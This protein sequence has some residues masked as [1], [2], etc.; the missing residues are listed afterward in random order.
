MP[1][2]K[3]SVPWRWQLEAGYERCKS[4]SMVAKLYKTKSKTVSKWVKRAKTTGGVFDKPRQGMPQIQL[5]M[6]LL[7]H[8]YKTA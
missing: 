8:F 7:N 6:R 4:Y 2:Q 1:P 3:G 5:K